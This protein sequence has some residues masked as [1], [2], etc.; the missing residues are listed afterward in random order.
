MNHVI[1]LSAG[2]NLGDRAL[3]LRN[4]AASLI[5][6]IHPLVLSSIY[7]TEPW[8]Y[9]DQP[10]F[11]NQVIKASTIL[12]PIELLTFLKGI[13]VFLGRQETFRFGPR[14]IDLDILFYDDLVIDTPRLTIP[15]PRISERAFVLIP[16]AEVAPNLL[17]PVLKKTI[18]ALKAN[19]DTSSV[20]L[21]QPLKS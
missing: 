6:E 18:L 19:V 4:A 13:E 10:S 11:L 20:E 9:A 2:S 17:H 12:E 8:G 7:E 1:Y 5:P 3:N 16:L 21:F 14:L 15:H